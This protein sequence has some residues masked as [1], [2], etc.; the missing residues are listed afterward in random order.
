MPEYSYYTGK[1]ELLQWVNDILDLQLAGLEEF[2]NGAVYCQL[3]DA[4][5]ADTVNM[6]RVNFHARKDYEVLTNYKIFQAAVTQVGFD[7][8]LKAQ[9]LVKGS[10]GEL[11]ELLQWLFVTL[12]KLA[13]LS[14]YDTQGRR[15]I[16]ANGDIEDKIPLPLW[17]SNKPDANK[18]ETH[19]RKIDISNTRTPAKNVPSRIDTGRGSKGKTTRK[20]VKPER[21]TPLPQTQSNHTSSR[22]PSP[23]RAVPNRRTGSIVSQSVPRGKQGSTKQTQGTGD[24]R[25]KTTIN[26]KTD[27]DMNEILR[28]VMPH[29]VTAAAFGTNVFA[30]SIDNLKS[31]IDYI[32]TGQ[33][34]YGCRAKVH[35]LRDAMSTLVNHSSL[36]L[37]EL[38]DTTRNLFSM[39]LPEPRQL[40]NDL[41]A[42]KRELQDNQQLYDRLVNE[43]NRAEQQYPVPAVPY[44]SS[45]L[46][47]MNQVSDSTE[48]LD[49]A[50]RKVGAAKAALTRALQ[51]IGCS[52]YTR[53]R[54]SIGGTEDKSA[55]SDIGDDETDDIIAIGFADDSR[56]SENHE[57]YRGRYANGRKCGYGVYTFVNGDLYYGEFNDDEMHGYGLYTFSH[58]GHY[59]GQWIM[60]VY[61][62][63]GTETFALGSTYH[64]QYREGSRNGWGV[65]RYYN[66]DYYEGQWKDGFREG[67]GMQQCTD[68]SNFVGDYLHGK[69]HGY[70]I[71][72]FP[73]GDRYF[74][75]YE[76]DIPHGYGVYRF[77]N[78][79]KYEGQWLAGKKHGFCVYT[80]ET[81]GNWERWAGEWD[82]GSPIWVETLNRS[83]NEIVGLNPELREKV[84]NALEA[85]KR[86][87]DSGEAGLSRLDEHWKTDSYI[88]KSIRDVVWKADKAAVLARDAQRKALQVAAQ[89]EAK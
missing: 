67:R 78:G 29:C 74:G 4:Y 86:A 26:S 87:Q 69:R 54:M 36:L 57:M 9:G 84:Q 21:A 20:Y 72:N 55:V 38:L 45:V 37:G 89:L 59:E 68:E 23:P 62:G 88:Q 66:G 53:S 18:S 41:N 19:P 39:K 22:L 79:Q 75:E 43:L 3:F 48:N 85:C 42:I 6:H 61:E 33:D 81:N 64:G 32:G 27:L 7:R 25:T 51:K 82:S 49:N 30:Q 10:Q 5:F 47:R 77:S 13:P 2:S 24:S 83:E 52:N 8:D 65:C 15:E 46:E 31:L 11:L 34:T 35:S 1:T 73:N 56:Q 70:G 76:N 58:E 14:N 17:L 12:Q 80:V 28:E 71:Y 50:L 44:S 16:S 63:V 60:G 40:L